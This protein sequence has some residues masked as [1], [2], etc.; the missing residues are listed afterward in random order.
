MPPSL[1]PQRFCSETSRQQ[2]EDPIGS[3]RRTHA[4]IV[5]EYPLPWTDPDWPD[6]PLFGAIFERI[7]VLLREKG[8]FVRSLVIAPDPAYADPNGK[9]VLILQ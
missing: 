3:A 9:H 2:G 7:G 8:I 1:C 4:W 5:I 6:G